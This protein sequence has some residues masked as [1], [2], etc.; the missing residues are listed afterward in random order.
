MSFD[1]LQEYYERQ[2]REEEEPTPLTDQE[3]DDLMHAE[4]YEDM[5]DEDD[6]EGDDE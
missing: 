6:Y 3:I 5:R 1:T 4:E 2:L